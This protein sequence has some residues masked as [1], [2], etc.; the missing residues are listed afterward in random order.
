MDPGPTVSLSFYLWLSFLPLSRVLSRA[1]STGDVQRVG[2]LGRTAVVRGVLAAGAACT[3]LAGQCAVRTA[4]GF[5]SWLPVIERRSVF[6]DLAHRTPDWG[7]KTAAGSLLSTYLSHPASL[8]LLLLFLLV[9]GARGKV[10]MEGLGSELIT[11][12][13]AGM[14]AAL[15]YGSLLLCAMLLD[16]CQDAAAREA[17]RGQ[18]CRLRPA[19]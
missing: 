5:A 7:Y 6:L 9:A 19:E 13:L 18:L 3:H 14:L 12:L 15:I 2:H 8:L 1:F 10:Q 16:D 17:A 11:I 4:R